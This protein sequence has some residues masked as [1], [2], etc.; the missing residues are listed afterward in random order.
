MAE[1][2]A[3]TVDA[4]VVYAVP[5]RAH[6]FESGCQPIL[7]RAAI[8]PADPDAVPELADS[9]WTWRV[10]RS[11]GL[12]ATVR[13][14]D[15]I[16]IYRPLTVDPKRAASARRIERTLSAHRPVSCSGFR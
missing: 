9:N 7:G 6:L 10:R 11:C 5:G 15:R 16:E 4:V 3:G 13:D 1:A 12:E 2:T 14:G 8:R